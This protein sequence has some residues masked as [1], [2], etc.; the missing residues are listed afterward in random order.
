MGTKQTK[1]KHRAAILPNSFIHS[2]LILMQLHLCIII[3]VTI[4]FDVG[5]IL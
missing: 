3:I 5:A 1:E 4:M 2:I